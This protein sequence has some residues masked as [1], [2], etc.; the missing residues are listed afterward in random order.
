M[1]H[2]KSFQAC[3]SNLSSRSS[4]PDKESR[5]RVLRK[6]FSPLFAH[7]LPPRWHAELILLQLLF[8]I[9][10]KR[11]PSKPPHTQCLPGISNSRAGPQSELVAVESSSEFQ[12]SRRASPPALLG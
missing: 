9:H 5:C 4:A 6:S 11:L 7:P 2:Q 3:L 1:A 10:Q 12:A 8:A